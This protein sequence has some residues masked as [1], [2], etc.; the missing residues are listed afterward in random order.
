[1]REGSLRQK[2]AFRQKSADSAYDTVKH[3]IRVAR[4]NGW[5]LETLEIIPKDLF[6]EEPEV[7][8][9]KQKTERDRIIKS[10]LQRF[11][12]ALTPPI[13]P[14]LEQHIKSKDPDSLLPWE[15]EAADKLQTWRQQIE[16]I[17]PQIVRELSR[18][19]LK[20]PDQKEF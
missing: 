3:I 6:T 20:S 1:M 12:Q 18:A 16:E 17:K 7:L 5:D 2:S 14:D 19:V 4:K 9:A 15:K 10:V 11:A 8:S 13:P